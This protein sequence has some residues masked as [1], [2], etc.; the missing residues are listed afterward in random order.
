LNH[1][2]AKEKR[3]EKKHTHP[4]FLNTPSHT[5]KRIIPWKIKKIPPS[6]LEKQPK[7]LL[8]MP[9]KKQPFGL[10]PIPKTIHLSQSLRKKP[11]FGK[12]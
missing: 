7:L 1:H 9:P 5:T 4:F 11:S 3:Q 2:I 6:Y 8:P 10:V 12:R